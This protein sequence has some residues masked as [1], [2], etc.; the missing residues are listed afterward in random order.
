MSRFFS[1]PL[2]TSDVIMMQKGTLPKRHVHAT[3]LACHCLVPVRRDWDMVNKSFFH[4]II[5]VLFVW[6]AEALG[7]GILHRDNFI[8]IM[9]FLQEHTLGLFTLAVTIAAVSFHAKH[10]HVHKQIHGHF[11]IMTPSLRLCCVCRPCHSLHSLSSSLAEVALFVYHHHH[12]H[13]EQIV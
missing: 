1:L 7:L 12:P 9:I 10:Q 11:Y 2:D 8:Y 13:L 5:C 4:I 6:I 3:S